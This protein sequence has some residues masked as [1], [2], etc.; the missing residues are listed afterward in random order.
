M[1]LRYKIL[2]GLF[3]VL[4]IVL[5]AGALTLSYTAPCGAAPEVGGDGDDST[6]AW[7]RR[8]YGPPDVLELAR[9]ARPA[10]G[11]QDVV[12]RVHAASLNPLDRHYLYG[13]P[14]VMRLGSG[15]GSPENPRIGVDFAGVVEAVGERV[16]RFAIGDRVYGGA[17]GAFAE[18]LVVG[19]DR[20]L[21]RIPDSVSFEAAAALPIA[22]VSALQALRDAGNVQAGDKVLINGASGGVG[23]FAV[24]IAKS[25]GAEVHGVCSTPNVELVREL[26]ADRVFDYRKESYLDSGETY[27]VIVDMVGNYSARANRKAMKPG[28]TLVLVGGPKGDWIAP[29]K[30]PLG[31]MLLSPFVDERF[32]PF[33][34][35]FNQEDLSLLAAMLEDGSLRAVIGRRFDLAEVPEAFRFYEDVGTQGKIVIDVR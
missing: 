4:A 12:I 13:S 31:A 1:K 15:I 17:T 32:E 14:Y 8:C 29:L 23:T 11:E 26:G 22:A 34:A 21:V 30:R 9:F 28:G 25:F 6:R 19:E 10:P 20:A 7:V 16:T 5:L 2:S 3:G 33:L 24:Q 35:R 18:Y 27:D